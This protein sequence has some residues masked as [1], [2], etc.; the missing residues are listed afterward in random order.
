MSFLKVNL[1]IHKQFLSYKKSRHVEN[2][3]HKLIFK[4]EVFRTGNTLY[5]K[6]KA[7]FKYQS[8]IYIK[9]QLKDKQVRDNRF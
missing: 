8:T 7:A 4:L 6:N 1:T 2:S 9:N 5:T 3:L